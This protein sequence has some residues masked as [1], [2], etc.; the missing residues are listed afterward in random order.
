MVVEYNLKITAS[1]ATY[2]TA[3]NK[4]HILG[5]VLKCKFRGRF[6][7]C[8]RYGPQGTP[9]L[10]WSDIALLW[11]FTVIQLCSELPALRKLAG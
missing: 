1:C 2:G 3:K 5:M 4:V 6:C 7:A 11:D 9:I 8:V 10:E